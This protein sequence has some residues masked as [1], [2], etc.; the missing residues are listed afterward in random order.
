MARRDLGKLLQQLPPRGQRLPIVHVKLEGRSVEETARLTGLS[1]SAIKVGIH[2]R[3]KALAAEDSRWRMK[4]DDLIALLASEVAPADRLVVA[5]RF[6]T[7]LRCGLA[8]ALLLIVTAYVHPRTALAPAIATTPL[9]WAKLAL[10][11]YPA[12]R[13]AVA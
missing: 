7:A 6:A 2:R 12:L 13:R 5:K 9:F 10:P 3:L 11:A 1:S 8:G 4:T